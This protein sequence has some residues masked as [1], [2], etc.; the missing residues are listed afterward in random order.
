LR[1]AVIGAG[2]IGEIRAAAVRHTPG[3]ALA[4]IVDVD[5]SKAER[6]AAAYG[7]AAAQDAHD[8]IGSGDIDVVIVSTPPHL[9]GAL[10]IAALD[11]KT[12][13]ICEKPLSHTLHDA[14]AMV[15]AAARNGVRLFTG[16]NHRYFP[17][18]QY[19][20]RLID[21]GRIGDVISAEAFAGHPGG[22]E[23]GNDWV[24][25]HAI[26]G[27][28]ALVDNGI[29]V[30]DMTRWLFGDVVRAKGYIN[31][32]VWQFGQAE[33]NAYALF[34]NENK[35]VARVHASWT[36]WRG[37]RWW[38]EVCGTRGYVRAGYP[39]MSV[40]WGQTPQPGIRSRRRWE[41][42]PALQIHERLRTWRYTVI[43]AFIAEMA[44][45]RSDILNG[46]FNA[47]S[48]HDGLRAL[49]MAHAVYTSAAQGNEVDV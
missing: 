13:V 14:E 45:V 4:A 43:Q 41:W 39:P 49:Q 36:H 34:I 20:R 17:P 37:Y 8:V 46:T 22:A 33:D 29:H 23:F 12:H 21:A 9:H 47:P 32:A 3:L 5:K 19:A 15:A 26:T 27:G 31:N 7:G 35:Q 1:V 25:K 28:G 11:A 24:M 10:S 38:V 30:L 6:A 40:E 48:G 16:F 2:G 42:F 44:D 18:M